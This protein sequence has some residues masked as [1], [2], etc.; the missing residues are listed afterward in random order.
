MQRA[1]VL[2]PARAQA[3][4]PAE[5]PPQKRGPRGK[6]QAARAAAKPPGED[7]AASEARPRQSG[8]RALRA[9]SLR[10]A[11]CERASDRPGSRAAVKDGCLLS[12][13]LACH[14]A[15]LPAVLGWLPLSLMASDGLRGEP[16]AAPSP[17]VACIMRRRVYLRRPPAH[18][19]RGRACFFS[20]TPVSFTCRL[21]HAGACPKRGLA[22]RKQPPEQ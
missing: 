14:R 1:V 2:S 16:Q 19:V 10:P 17:M 20:D 12:E 7:L 9:R 11:A 18:A 3:P 13:A 5:E 8:A 6:K 15:A 22:V 21:R 4:P